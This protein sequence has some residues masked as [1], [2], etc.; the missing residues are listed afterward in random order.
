[1]AAVVEMG[2]MG[3]MGETAPAMMGLAIPGP[4]EPQVRVQA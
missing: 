3:E 2:E 1:M 4:A